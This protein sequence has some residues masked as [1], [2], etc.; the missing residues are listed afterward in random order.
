MFK[1]NRW[2]KLAGI[3]PN[4]ETKKET[5]KETLSEGFQSFGMAPV[6]VMGGN[7]FERGTS[8]KKPTKM[9]TA[10][11]MY[12]KWRVV[13]ESVGLDEAIIKNVDHPGLVKQLGEAVKSW[14]EKNNGSNSINEASVFKHRDP[15]PDAEDDAR[16]MGDDWDDENIPWVATPNDK[17]FSRDDFNPE[18]EG[19][20]T[21]SIDDYN[22]PED[23]SLLDF[24]YN[25]ESG[26]PGSRGRFDNNGTFKALYEPDDVIDA[27]ISPMP[28][29]KNN[30]H[31]K[32]LTKEAS[33]LEMN[34][35]SLSNLAEEMRH[36]LL[37]VLDVLDRIMAEI[38]KSPEEEQRKIY[39]VANSL[40]A[41]LKTISSLGQHSR[42]NLTEDGRIE[43]ADEIF[44][45]AKRTLASISDLLDLLV[46]GHTKYEKKHLQE[47]RTNV[48]RAM[49]HMAKSRTL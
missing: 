43:S 5:K 35:G 41:A 24:D 26:W 16:L 20:S 32:R 46:K 48:R 31:G 12:E 34:E 17:D 19:L 44:L 4:P 6:G 22:E 15:S 27:S 36:K 49:M 25:D 14:V 8:S 39:D 40:R 7:P 9:V 13:F 42:R 29:E 10:A 23:E 28:W 38:S 11:S 3:S 1:K 21:R 37:D 33:D 30:W 18:D 45:E 47:A 2:M